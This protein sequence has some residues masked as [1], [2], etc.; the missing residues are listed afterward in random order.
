MTGFARTRDRLFGVAA[1][2][3]A[4][5]AVGTVG[6]RLIEGWSFLDSL[7]MTVIT[8]ATVGYGEVHPLSPGGRV[9]TMLLILGGIGLFTYGFSTIAAILVEGELSEAFRRRRMEKDIAKLSGHY[10]VC[11]A[12]HTG[13]VIC[14]ELLKTGRSF[15]VVDQN[16]ETVAKQAERLGAEFPFVLGDGTDDDVLRR[17]GVERAA[18]VFA[19][20]SSD[21]DNAFVVLS[22][23]GLNPK[24]RVLACQK[25]L[26][27]R[28][29]LLRSG[30]DGV[31]DPEF[32]GGLRLASEMIRPV[33]VG[34]LDSMLR[35]KGEHVRFDEVSVPSD[36]FLVGRPLDEVRG[37]GS[38]GPLL[39]AV[40]PAGSGR[41]EINPPADRPVRAGDRLVMIGETA[42][43]AALR[44]R[45]GAT[46]NN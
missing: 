12:G 27:V 6:Y 4:C 36:S 30:A 13:G 33:T 44:R 31:V 34:F 15:V 29:K 10:V 5:L 11:G 22:A 42:A 46:S 20:L 16:A 7:Y 21:Q 9:F 40:V 2:L 41:Y 37:A 1:L 35:E 14:A 45:V 43:L 38:G 25:T 17:A 18:G 19:V 39:V 24:A 3:A 23:K 8:V 32:I 26:G 28:D